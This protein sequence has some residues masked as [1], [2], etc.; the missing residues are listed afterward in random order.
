MLMQ[1]RHVKSSKSLHLNFYVVLQTA[2]RSRLFSKIIC[3]ICIKKE[4]LTQIFSFEFCDIFKNTLF[5]ENLWATASRS[6][7]LTCFCT[8]YPP[9]SYKK[10]ER[11][12]YDVLLLSL[13]CKTS[14]ILFKPS[15]SSILEPKIMRNHPGSLK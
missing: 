15:R 12:Y 9:K 7:K 1:T 5:T 6:L 3:T 8:I 11:F 14:F 13:W 2:T 10:F 4:T